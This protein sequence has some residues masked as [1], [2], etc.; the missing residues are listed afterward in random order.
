MY[1]AELTQFL[2]TPYH[3]YV[4]VFPFLG[5]VFDCSQNFQL[6]CTLFYMTY[7]KNINLCSL[8]PIACLLRKVVQEIERRI[9]TQADHIRSVRQEQ[10]N[11][12]VPTIFIFVFNYIYYLQ[13]NNLIKAREEKYQSRIRVLETLASGT[14]EETQ[15]FLSVCSHIFLGLIARLNLYLLI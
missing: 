7:A 12:I 8:Q 14:S 3:D 15:V 1:D 6:Q 13:Q 9:L 2:L 10:Y 5:S 4:F 11:F